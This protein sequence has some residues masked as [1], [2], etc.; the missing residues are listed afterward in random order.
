M[1]TVTSAGFRRHLPLFVMQRLFDCCLCRGVLGARRFRSWSI[2]RHWLFGLGQSRGALRNRWYDFWFSFY[3]VA[4]IAKTTRAVDAA[5][6]RNWHISERLLP[7][8]SERD[9]F[10]NRSSIFRIAGISTQL[11]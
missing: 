10:T 8:A 7:V 1:E 6:G 5:E 3:F 9:R 11:A 4:Y 2:G